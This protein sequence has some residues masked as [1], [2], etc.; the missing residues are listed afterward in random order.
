MSY[1]YSRHS[2]RRCE[3]C[4]KPC[5]FE[6]YETRTDGRWCSYCS[7]AQEYKPMYTMKHCSKKCYEDTIEC[8][9][10]TV[11][12]RSRSRTRA[13]RRLNMYHELDKYRCKVCGSVSRQCWCD[14]E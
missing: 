5:Y 14:N 9:E 7:I 11:E 1:N 8:L 6:K 12:S 13:I 10:A 2:I 4:D 3:A